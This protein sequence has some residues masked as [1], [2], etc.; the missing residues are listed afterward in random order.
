MTPTDDEIT[1]AWEIA[2]RGLAGPWTTDGST[3][4]RYMPDAEHR[5]AEVGRA[6]TWWWHAWDRGRRLHDAPGVQ[7][8][9]YPS[10][11]AAMA[12]ADDALRAAGVALVSG[13]SALR[14][15]IR[16]AILA[17]DDADCD[18]LHIR[19]VLEMAGAEVER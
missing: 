19:A 11:E 12:A 13:D 9:D 16:A 1:R 17:C 8:D 10:A 14:T 6:D 7:R 4:S 3:W 18:V 5:Y 2:R 15:V